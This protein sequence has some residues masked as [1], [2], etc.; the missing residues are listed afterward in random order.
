MSHDAS[1]RDADAAFAEQVPHHA[2]VTAAPRARRHH[3]RPI[4]ASWR[5]TA[6]ACASR[7]GEVLGADR[8]ERRRQVDA[9]ED[10]RRRRRAERRHDP[11]RRR[12][13][14]ALTVAG[15]MAAGI[16]F[17][18]QELNLFDN[19]DVAANVFIGREPRCGGP[20][21]LIDRRRRCAPRSRRCWSALGVDFAARHAGRRSVA[22]PAPAAWR[23]PRRCRS[24]PASSSWTSRPR[25]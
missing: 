11:H 12:G 14:R 1:R 20:L 3:A 25:A 16:A 6:S 22:R 2:A 5:S 8:R 15:A 17:V 13:A 23:S 19:L 21:E 4:R 7:R 9:D 24:T 10:P 18:H